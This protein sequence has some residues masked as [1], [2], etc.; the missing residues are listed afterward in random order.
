VQRPEATPPVAPNAAS[1]LPPGAE[2]IAPAQAGERCF[3]CGKGGKVF[4]VRRQSGEEASQMHID[5]AR[6]AWAMLPEEPFE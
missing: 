3:V 1:E 5:C 6:K 2:I 4:L